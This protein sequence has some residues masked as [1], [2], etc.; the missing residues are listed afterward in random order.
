MGLRDQKTS[1][2]KRLIRSFVC[3]WDGI[4]DVFR[5]ER[6]F[7]I[8]CF[9]T[10]AAV[11]AGIVFRISAVEWFMITGSIGAVLS[12]E[13]MN[14]AIERTVDLITLESHPLAKAAK[15]AAAGAVLIAAVTAV[16]IG[17]LIFVPRLLGIF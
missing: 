2:S 6:N 13:L 4:M 10:L 1:E 3:A 9:F 7:Q 12:L 17:L 8:H 16:I 14:T 11:T 5:H 15:D